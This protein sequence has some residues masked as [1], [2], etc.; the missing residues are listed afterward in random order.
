[1]STVESIAKEMAL[2]K[3]Y[4]ELQFAQ[5]KMRKALVD[6][7]AIPE[8]A[9]VL[10]IG[11]GQGDL[12]A[13]LADTVGSKGKV[14]A[15]DSASP[16]YGAPITIGAS[17]DH[18]RDGPYGEIVDIRLGYDILADYV[19]REHAPFHAVILGHCSWYFGSLNLLGDILR[20]AHPWAPMICLSEWD[21]FPKNTRQISHSLAVMIQG[22]VEAFRV[23]S[24]AN[25]RSPYA[26][27]TL[28]RVLRDAGWRVVGKT[29]IDCSELMDGI[30][31][32]D[33]CLGNILNCAS[34]LAIPE[35][36]LSL[37]R[38]EVDVLREMTITYGKETLASF[39][40]T[41]VAVDTK[42]AEQT[43]AVDGLTAATD[44]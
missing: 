26:P 31:E 39:A 12:T 42:T 30:W 10:E 3:R 34:A 6:A 33:G 40:L 22:Q 37:L 20:S 14:L 4:P 11:C 38:S 28:S 27:S 7:W 41:A 43:D 5:T 32:I 18:L 1:M 35:R 13:V 24:N 17:L 23:S 9:H 29:S 2:F 19:H 8:G 25:I 21:L 16:E 15:V 36:M 44:L